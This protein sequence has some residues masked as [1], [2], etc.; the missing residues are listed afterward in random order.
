MSL[1][2]LLDW[3]HLQDTRSLEMMIASHFDHT[4]TMLSKLENFA[5]LMILFVFTMVAIVQRGCIA[6]CAITYSGSV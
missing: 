1:L 4:D 6:V 5:T 3:N 2:A